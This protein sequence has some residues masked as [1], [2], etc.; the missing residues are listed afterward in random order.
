MPLFSAT[1]TTLTLGIPVDFTTTGDI[2]L[3][4]LGTQSNGTWPSA[5]TSGQ[6]VLAKDQ[7]SGAL[8][9]VYI[10]ASGTWVRASD[11]NSTSNILQDTYFLVSNT[12]GTSLVGT[13]WMLVTPE[14]YVIGTTNLTFALENQP[15]TSV[16]GSTLSWTPPAAGADGMWMTYD[17]LYVRIAGNVQRIASSSAE[18]YAYTSTT[19]SVTNST[20]ETSVFPGPVALSVPAQNTNNI[21]NT[22]LDGFVSYASLTDTVT[23]KIKVGNVVLA[24]VPVVGSGVA[25]AAINTLYHFTSDLRLSSQSAS[26]TTSTVSVSGTLSIVTSSGAVNFDVVGSGTV[27]TTLSSVLDLTATWSVASTSD[28]VSVYAMQVQHINNI[29][30][31]GAS[32]A[33][34]TQLMQTL[35]VGTSVAANLALGNTVLIGAAGVPGQ[36]TAATTITFSNPTVGSTTQLLFAQGT[37]SYPVTFTIA[38]YTFYQNGKTTGVASG[39]AVLQAA[40]MTLNCFYT[41]NITWLS[42][43]TA[44]VSLL[45]S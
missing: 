12:T 30:Y 28:T 19:T 32:S 3:S 31:V 22:T 24:T 44:S 41:C 13:G 10:A 20:T 35:S 15:T 18:Y 2:T 29:Q 45:K 34:A 38:G 6:R 11:F 39:S 36:L 17:G 7:S 33:T 16:S 25:G 26:G 23:F 37:T 27:N 43:T 21:V 42:N 9:G 5:L 40:D 14:P 4:G 8:N 1:T